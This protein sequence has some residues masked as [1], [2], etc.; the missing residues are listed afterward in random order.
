M[1]H[2]RNATSP[3]HVIFCCLPFDFLSVTNCDALDK[4]F[5]FLFRS[6]P[7]DNVILNKE[8]AKATQNINKVIVMK[9]F[10]KTAASDKFPLFPTFPSPPPKHNYLNAVA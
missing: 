9:F 3:T 2:K 7:N 8:V 4:R 5:P 10:K 6:P 1:P